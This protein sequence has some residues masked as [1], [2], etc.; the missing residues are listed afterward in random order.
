MPLRLFSCS[1]FSRVLYRYMA[2]ATTSGRAPA[3]AQDCAS[4]APR[5]CELT[6]WQARGIQL[7]EVTRSSM[8]AQRA[9][10]A[11]HRRGASH[12]L[13]TAHLLLAGKLFQD[14]QSRT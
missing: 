3:L 13:Y 2:M 8:E 12:R 1:R 5:I 10:A 6:S 7:G 9:L 4:L 14:R 11:R